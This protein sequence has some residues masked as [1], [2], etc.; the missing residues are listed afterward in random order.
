MSRSCLDSNRSTIARNRSWLASIGM[1]AILFGMLASGALMA[2]P[3]RTA[4]TDLPRTSQM[5]DDTS[6]ALVSAANGEIAA[7]GGA[8]AVLPVNVSNVTDLGAVTVVLSYEPTHLKP[9]AYRRNVDLF[10]IGF[11][12]LAFDRDQDGTPDSVKFN[13]GALN[14]VDV[15]ADS[16][17]PLAAITWQV[18]GTVAVGTTTVLSVTVETFTDSQALPLQSAAQN[19][20]VTFVTPPTATS[21]PAATSTATPSATST[22]TPSPVPTTIPTMTEVNPGNSAAFLPLISSQ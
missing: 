20:T 10:N 14:G 21:T 17:A 11:A 4:T 15:P 7:V 3:W 8:Q 16:P 12:N 19:G 22:A 6:I 18:T 1:L 5:R 13:V 2:D 9:I